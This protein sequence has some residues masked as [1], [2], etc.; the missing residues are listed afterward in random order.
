MG[1]FHLIDNR[2][3]D[4]PG[5]MYCLS[6]GA[7]SDAYHVGTFD[8]TDIK[9]KHKTWLNVLPEHSSNQQGL[10]CGHI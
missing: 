3:K 1:T 2:I 9:I 5:S 6:M 8:V 4:R 10:P 7:V